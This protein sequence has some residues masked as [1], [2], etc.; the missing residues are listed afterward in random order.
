MICFTVGAKWRNS[1]ERFHFRP[2]HVCVAAGRL[3]LRGTARWLHS[4]QISLRPSMERS[5]NSAR[6]PP[7]RRRY[8]I[9][10]KPQR[11]GLAAAQ[12]KRLIRSAALGYIKNKQFRAPGVSCDGA[13]CGTA[14]PDPVGRVPPRGDPSV[15]K[16][17]PTIHFGNSAKRIQK[18][19]IN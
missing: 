1:S 14:A 8:I 18:P 11:G 12:G 2:V 3:K 6:Q 19:L 17:N 13:K 9:R 7:G 10:P 16:R 4:S 15:A 5:R